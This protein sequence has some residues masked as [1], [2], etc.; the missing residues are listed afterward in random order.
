MHILLLKELLLLVLLLES[1]ILKKKN[2]P[3]A[4]KNNAPFI[5][6][7]SKI[8][9]VLIE[10]AEDL[11]TVMP[12][13]NLLEYSKNYSKIS[14]SLCNYYG[15]ELT[16]DTNDDNNLNKNVI[17]SKSFKHKTSI[18]GN[19]YNIPGRIHNAAGQAINNPDYSAN[20][21][22]T[23]KLKIAMPLKYLSN[24]WRALDMPLINCEVSLTLTW[25]E[26]C[27]ITSLEKRRIRNTNNR[28]NS[29][30][31]VAFKITDCKLHV[32]VVTL[33]AENDNKL[34]EQLKT[35]FERTHGINIE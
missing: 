4:F 24:F 1:I 14:G 6:C 30:T 12:M 16:D 2:R 8:N 26:N 33:S 3:L 7:I 10:N 20:K 15:D 31:N 35:G 9:G 28:G 32:R 29:P 17:N 13:Y 34:L 23:K 5:S 21:E 22:G 25:S 19:T 18:T 27:V 11:D